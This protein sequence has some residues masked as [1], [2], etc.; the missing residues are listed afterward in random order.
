MIEGRVGAPAYRLDFI[1]ASPRAVRELDAQASPRCDIIRTDQ[2][3]VMSDH[4]P[5]ECVWDRNPTDPLGP[6]WDSIQRVDFLP[7]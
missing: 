3:R 2:T 5:V 6:L 7:E 4:F 1:L